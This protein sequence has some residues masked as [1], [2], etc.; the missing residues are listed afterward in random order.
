MTAD[1][2]GDAI[3][4]DGITGGTPAALRRRR[5]VTVKFQAPGEVSKIADGGHVP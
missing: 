3:V 5:T 4:A 1:G 2:S